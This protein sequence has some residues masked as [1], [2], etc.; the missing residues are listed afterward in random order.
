MN[1]IFCKEISD[2]S[3]S[4]E[5]IIPESLGNKSH[6]LSKGIVCDRCNNYFALKIEKAVLDIPYFKSLRHRHYILNKKNRLP[7]ET[8][9][10]DHQTGGDLEIVNRDGNILTV[11]AKDQRVFNLLAEGKITRLYIPSHVLPADDNVFIS[12]L[13]G[14]IALEALAELVQVVDNWNQDFVEHVGLDDLRNYVRYGIGKF[15]VY[16]VRKVYSEANTIQTTSIADEERV[17]QLLHEYDFLYIDGQYLYFVCIIMG[18]EYAIN[19]AEPILTQYEDWLQKNSYKS[20]L[21]A[22]M[23]TQKR[24]AVHEQFG[25]A[26]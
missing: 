23:Q 25:G 22:D 10:V 1:C 7:S 26:L 21:Q 2:G 15:W 11:V 3:K 17:T 24:A 9:F 6:I 5:H 20:P 18:V 12:R 13:L 16:N 14:K 4:V 8:A 19:L